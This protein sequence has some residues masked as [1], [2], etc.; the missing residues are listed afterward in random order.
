MRKAH[1]AYSSKMR[2]CISV[3]SSNAQTVLLSL[4]PPWQHS[5]VHFEMPL[6][7]AKSLVKSSD[8]KGNTKKA[9]K[10]F[11]EASHLEIKVV[12]M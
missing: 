11:D 3:K 5:P 7:I 10:R 12:S 1:Q 6:F 2:V 4:P 8:R 9:Q